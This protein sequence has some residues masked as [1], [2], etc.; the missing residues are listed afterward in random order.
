MSWFSQNLL[1]AACLT[2]GIAANAQTAGVAANGQSSLDDLAGKFIKYVRADRKEKVIVL[3]DKPFYSAGETI[4]L[5]AWCLDS[6]SNRFLYLSKNLFVDLVDDE[7]S[8]ISQL[9]LNIPARKTAGKILLPASLGEGYY[10]L[11][12]YTG[13]MLNGDSGRIFVKP[14]Y[15]VN[16]SKPNPRALRAAYLN[17]SAQAGNGARAGNSVRAGY[18]GQ[19]GNGAQP[20]PDDTAAPQTSFYAEGGSIISGTT[21]TVAFRSQSADGSPV[22]VSGYVT[23]PLHD[24]VSRL[25]SVQGMG[26]FSFDAYNPRKYTVHIIWRGRELLYALPKLDQFASQLTVIGRDDRSIKL[27]VSLG[28]S[29]YNKHKSTKILGISRDSLCFAAIGTDM[30]Q[31]NV[32]I[33]NFP[34]GRVC[35]LLF[36]DRDNLVSQRSVY[37]GSSD[38]GRIVAATDKANYSPGDKVNLSIGVKTQNS[39]PVLTT[40][41][42]VAVTDN[43]L[44]GDRGGGEAGGAGGTSAGGA[45]AA[46][47]GAA[48]GTGMAGM[49]ANGAAG[50]P[51]GIEGL[52]TTEDEIFRGYPADALDV[53]M[54]LERPGYGDWGKVGAA[55][56]GEAGASASGTAGGAAGG[57]ASRAAGGMVSGAAGPSANG[58]G[59]GMVRYLDSNLLNLRGKAVS[60]NNEPLKKYI[61]NLV[62]GDNNLFLADTTDAEGRFLFP[63][64][65]FDDGTKFNLKLTDLNG[66]AYEGKVILDKIDYPRFPTPRAKKRGFNSDEIAMLRRYRSLPVTEQAEPPKDTGLLKP[67]VVEARKKLPDYDEAKRVSPF[68]YIIGPDQL[69]RGGVDEVYNALSQVPGL[70]T[71]INRN[72][73][74]G[75]MNVDPFYILMDGV[76][77][78]TG[79]DLKGFLESLDANNIEF[80]E[81]LKGAL[82]AIYGMQASG[83]VILINSV[84]MLHDYAQTNDKGLTT[85]YPK[86]Y[87]NQPD[88]FSSGYDKKKG[89]AEAADLPTLY[90]NANILTDN[91]GNAK[92]DFFTGRRQATYSAAIV[93]VTPGGD[94]VEKKIQIKCR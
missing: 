20:R 4:W 7:D 31:V 2:A 12:A 29:L 51:A 59:K 28:D 84:N 87:Y 69:R 77:V 55:G 73:S 93:G 74:S 15:V 81:V 56:S 37:I 34:V 92:V 78:S 6:L 71:G 62:S 53:L 85:I 44:T 50:S 80:I 36:D 39:N 5:K 67:A 1:L 17:S 38:S 14:V 45:G 63:L 89:A 46:A 94:I 32:P 22:D 60:K 90:W 11:R 10:W 57:T 3:T 25:K 23:D 79:G 27:Q 49:A 24:T 66:K 48:G 72:F 13:R 61:V 58:A 88:I 83:G 35:F 65:D 47:N 82:T 19:T 30:Y 68:S 26:K 54:L 52:P 42:S 33:A 76:P 8:V 16:P 40:L 43:R 9:L 41:L 70:T 91:L 18:G 21:A 86:G 75:T 64:S